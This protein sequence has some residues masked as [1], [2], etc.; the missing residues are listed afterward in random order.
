MRNH[1]ETPHS[2][3]MTYFDMAVDISHFIED[4]ELRFCAIIGHSMG[5]KTSMVVALTR[6]VLV[7]RLLVLNIAPVP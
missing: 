7:G 5:G 3:M 1:S 4:H 6:P 2:D